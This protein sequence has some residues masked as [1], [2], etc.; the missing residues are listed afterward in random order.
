MI[1]LR[2]YQ[3][4]AIDATYA[5]WENEGGSPLIELATGTGK[6]VVI[7]TMVRE[8]MGRF[9]GMRI[10]ALVHVKELVEQNVKAIMRLWPGVPIGINCARP[11]AAR[12]GAPDHL[13]FDPERGASCA[14]TRR[15]T[16]RDRG[17]VLCCR[18]KSCRSRWNTLY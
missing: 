17:R 3:R 1:A 14:S 18:N 13:R 7:A 11:R 15:A 4:A 10:L 16:S 2:S 6:S 8:L 12:Y 9:P 5:Y